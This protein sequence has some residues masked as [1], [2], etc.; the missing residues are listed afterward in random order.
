MY[1][2]MLF[3]MFNLVVGLPVIVFLQKR[4]NQT[5]SSQENALKK[6]QE[7]ELNDKI[8]SDVE[9]KRKYAVLESAKSTASAYQEKLDEHQ[10]TLKRYNQEPVGIEHTTSGTYY[11]YKDGFRLFVEN[12]VNFFMKEVK[13]VQNGDVQL[14]DT[15]VYK[16]LPRQEDG[17][18]KLSE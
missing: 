6:A 15:M 8:W 2:M 3:L 9:A 18:L 1:F 4:D 17:F 11:V 5:T 14:E 13:D 10:K 7:K 16:H 12:P